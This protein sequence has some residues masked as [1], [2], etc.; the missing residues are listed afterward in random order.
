MMRVKPLISVWSPFASLAFVLPLIACT[1]LMMA[2]YRRWLFDIRATE[3]W[4]SLSLI[5][6]GPLCA[7]IAA[8][9]AV[10]RGRTGL[11]PL[12]ATAA[13]TEGAQSARS[14][15]ELGALIA[16][17]LTLVFTAT[18]GLSLRGASFGLPR[19]SVALA[20]AG[21][22]LAGCALGLALGRR[23]PVV[24]IAPAASVTY[25]AFL[26]VP[27]YFPSLAFL[28]ALTPFGATPSAYAGPTPMYSLL[29]FGAGVA[30]SAWLLPKTSRRWAVGSAVA[31]CVALSLV[32]L[33]GASAE[34]TDSRATRVI[35]T[36]ESTFTL[37][38]T[39][40]RERD[41]GRLDSVLTTAFT[42]LAPLYPST[43]TIVQTIASDD[44]QPPAG[45]MPV[46]TT[47]A[48]GLPL[49]SGETVLPSDMALLAQVL[50]RLS[51]PT[52]QQAWERMTAGPPPSEVLIA[53]SYS[54]AGIPADGSACP[55]DCYVAPSTEEPGAAQFARSLAWLERRTDAQRRDWLNTHRQGILNGTLSY[56]DFR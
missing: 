21:W 31:A 28:G 8:Y 36:K 17:G 7:G 6:V 55:W 47:A 23:F 45:S 2:N 26:V 4:W 48:V 22:C 20:V 42:Q 27:V 25:Y 9:L 38:L 41:R 19:P 51:Q 5:I 44:T 15:I 10:R 53:W 32:A 35:C 14:L 37:C 54:A 50:Y 13:R 11:A 18:A 49:E 33:D 43:S 39:G 52:P 1:A 3:A 16:A 12:G 40:P 56:S 24:A 34:R 29:Q 46:L 30:L